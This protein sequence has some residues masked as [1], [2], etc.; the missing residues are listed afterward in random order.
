[1]VGVRQVLISRQAPRDQVRGELGGG[2]FA[3]R[4]QTSK[5]AIADGAYERDLRI[6][7]LSC[8]IA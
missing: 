6:G 2:E 5:R 8:G 4:K 7:S 1:V 3:P